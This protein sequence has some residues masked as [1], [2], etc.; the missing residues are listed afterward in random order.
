[1][2][3][4]IPVRGGTSGI[5]A[6][7]LQDGQILFDVENTRVYLD[8]LVNG[9]LTRSV[10]IKQPFVGTQAKWDALTDAQKAEYVG[11]T[12]IIL[13]DFV[14]ANDDFVPATPTT[15]GQAGLVPQPLAGEQDKVLTGGGTWKTITGLKSFIWSASSWSPGTAPYC[16]YSG[17]AVTFHTG[18]LPSLTITDA[19]VVTDVIT[20]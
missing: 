3:N 9:I 14:Q 2:G 8:H 12:V 17:E 10:F 15:A 7:A 1:M 5:D 16:T 19:E 20:S 18:T 11:T 6:R 4:F 13:D